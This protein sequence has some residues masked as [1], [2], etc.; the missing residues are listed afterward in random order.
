MQARYPEFCGTMIKAGELVDYPMRDRFR[1]LGCYDRL[2]RKL[3]KRIN[4]VEWDFIW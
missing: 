3:K 4:F 1:D 2:P